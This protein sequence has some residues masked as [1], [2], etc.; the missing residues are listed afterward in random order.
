MAWSIKKPYGTEILSPGSRQIAQN[1]ASRAATAPIQVH[2]HARNG[3]APNV[4]L[5]NQ[6]FEAANQ[7]ILYRTKE[8]FASSGYVGIYGAEV[9]SSAGAG[10]R[11]RWRFAFH[12]GVY[13]RA[14]MVNMILHPQDSGFTRNSAARVDIY[15]SATYGGSPVASATFNHGPGAN[16]TTIVYGLSYLKQSIQYM[17]GLSPDTD[18]YGI[19]TD[20]D[21][22]RAVSCSIAEM[23]SM[24]E[25]FDGYLPQNLT[26]ESPILDVYRERLAEVIYNLY[27]RG[28]ATV[29]NFS[30]DGDGAVRG[31]YASPTTLNNVPLNMINQDTIAYV[32]ADPGYQLDMTGCARLSQY[33]TGVPIRFCAYV[34]IPAANTGKVCLRDST[35]TIV[36]SLTQAGAYAG[37]V[38][39]TGLLPVG[40]DKYFITYERTSGA[41]MIEL[42]AVSCYQYE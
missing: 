25:T 17:E 29:F 19:V 10:D 20:V 32:D 30:T 22:G 41:D 5:I 9:P 8:V 2:L 34:D 6:F 24:S 13:S 18:Y 28:G 21:N 39:T 23:Q 12:T 3:K 14:L 1:P 38:T 27:R 15:T 37:W 26:A 36:T 42:Y 40:E 31:V 7:G 16:G 33:T 4:W 35:G 11:I